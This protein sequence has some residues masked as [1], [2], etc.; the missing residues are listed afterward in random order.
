MR[1][2]VS[3]LSINSFYIYLI[4]LIYVLASTISHA[5]YELAQHDNYQ[6]KLRQEIKDTKQANGGK[7][8]YDAVKNMVFMEKVFRGI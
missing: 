4:C 5:L 8:T 1:H 3:C 7:W 6:D 2:H